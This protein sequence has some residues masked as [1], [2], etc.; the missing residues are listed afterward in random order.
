MSCTDKLCKWSVMGVQGALISTI[1]R[2][3][4]Y[5]SGLLVDAVS[6]DMCIQEAQLDA[7]TRGI[8]HRLAKLYMNNP[9][10]RRPVIEVYV[11]TSN[12]RYIHGKAY[13]EH[14]I[15]NTD[16][17]TTATT[18]ASPLSVNWITNICNIYTDNT[19]ICNLYTSTNTNTNSVCTNITIPNTTTAAAGIPNSISKWD[20]WEEDR[21]MR[22]RNQRRDQVQYSIYECNGSVEIVLGQS[23]MLQGTNNNKPKNRAKDQD[24]SVD[25]VQNSSGVSTNNGDSKANADNYDNNKVGNNTIDTATTTSNTTTYK[26]RA[27]TNISTSSPVLSAPGPIYPASI[28]SRLSKIHYTVYYYELLVLIR[29]IQELQHNT[30]YNNDTT[31]KNI[32]TMDIFQPLELH[33]EYY[34]ICKQYNTNY[35]S[36][37]FL[38]YNGLNSPFVLWN[39]SSVLGSDIRNNSNA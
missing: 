9:K 28:C 16:N 4:I 21:V 10:L 37:L 25:V 38:F 22:Y 29:N 6:N 1:L 8:R 32:N 19:N 7:M 33:M 14:R 2:G 20:I 23:G 15:T 36:K 11:N 5:I 12:Q 39:R 3:G 18:K 34:Y 27:Y 35:Q 31:I 26:K 17:A 30:A 13:T 24:G